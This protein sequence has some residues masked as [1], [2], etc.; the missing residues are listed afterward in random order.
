LLPND[1]QKSH[2][3]YSNR[4]AAFCYLECYH[5]AEMDAIQA[6]QLVP[7]YGK[8]YARLGLSRFLLK[9]YTGAIQ[10]YE[11]ALQ[12]DPNNSASQSYLTKAQ[13]KLALQQQQQ[14]GTSSITTN[15]SVSSSGTSTRTGV[16]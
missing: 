16:V 3:Y 9:N 2:V 12:Y 1:V 15:A 7:T 4:A 13:Q 14:N 11:T 6:I 5:D 8:A 10:A